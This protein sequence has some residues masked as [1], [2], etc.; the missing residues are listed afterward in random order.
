[1]DWGLSF[2]GSSRMYYPLFFQIQLSCNQAVTLVSHFKFLLWWDRTK[3]ITHSPN[4]F[5]NH[6]SEETCNFGVLRGCELRDLGFCHLECSSSQ[7]S[8]GSASDWARWDTVKQNTSWAETAE[9]PEHQTQPV[10]PQCVDHWL[11]PLAASPNESRTIE[12]YS[13][14]VI[15]C[16]SFCRWRK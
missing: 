10:P 9:V 3:E 4:T 15:E 7:T 2:G 12:C 16:P 13:F 11:P 1:M 5:T 8:M 6:C 14:N